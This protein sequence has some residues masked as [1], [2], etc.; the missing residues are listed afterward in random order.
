MLYCFDK[1]MRL[2]IFNEFEKNDVAI[3]SAIVN[4]CSDI[5]DVPS[6]MSDYRNFINK[7]FDFLIMPQI[8]SFNAELI[9][10]E[11]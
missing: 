2:L 3:R 7:K 5:M 1:E 9:R 4:I 11:K 10:C 8:S 6:Y